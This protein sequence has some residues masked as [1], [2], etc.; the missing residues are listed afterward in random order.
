MGEVSL[1]RGTSPIRKRPP[2]PDHPM[3]LGICYCRILGGKLFF[4]SEVPLY[5]VSDFTPDQV[6]DFTEDQRRAGPA[7]SRSILSWRSQ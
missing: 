4:M 3:A 5:T 2:P 1:Y 7:A 6:S